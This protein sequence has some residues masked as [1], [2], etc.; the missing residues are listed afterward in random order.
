MGYYNTHLLIERFD[1]A[2]W[3]LAKILATGRRPNTEAA[4][5]DLLKNYSQR[6]SWTEDISIRNEN[7]TVK[8]PPAESVEEFCMKLELLK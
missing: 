7:I 6:S 4:D 1:G 5:E 3:N 2:Y 8:C